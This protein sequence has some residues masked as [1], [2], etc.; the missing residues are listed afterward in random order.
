MRP[1]RARPPGNRLITVLS[2]LLLV[3]GLVFVGMFAWEFYGTTYV[4]KKAAADGISQLRATWDAAGEPDPAATPGAGEEQWL[5]RIPALGPDYEWP[6][7][8]GIEPEDLARGVGWFPTSAQPGEIGNFAL[9]GHRVTNGEPFRHL[10]ELNPGDEVIIETRDAIHTYEITQSPQNLTVQDTESWVLYPVPG[11]VG[12]APTEALLTLTTCQDLFHS[13][14][15]SV[16]FGVLVDTTI[17][18][19][20]G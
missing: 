8:A 3:A 2:I 1:R 7:V 5:I 17:K 12:T 20:T 11:E 19:P 15:R 10:L 6:I 14:D 18:D 16:G 9:A 13:P 4:S